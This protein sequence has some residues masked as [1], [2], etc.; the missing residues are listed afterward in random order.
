[1]IQIPLFVLIQNAGFL[2]HENCIQIVFVLNFIIINTFPS[3]SFFHIVEMKTSQMLHSCERIHPVKTKQH[4]FVNRMLVE[5]FAFQSERRFRRI[6]A[7]SNKIMFAVHQ[8]TSSVI[9]GRIHSGTAVAFVNAVVVTS[10]KNFVDIKFQTIR[11]LEPPNR[12]MV[13]YHIC[14]F[15]IFRFLSCVEFIIDIGNSDFKI[16]IFKNVFSPVGNGI[17]EASA[18]MCEGLSAVDYKYIFY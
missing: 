13:N 2:F 14:P 4:T 12:K 11:N 3:R 1:M 10:R 18:R 5:K 7:C 17:V 16:L 8:S 9:D 15:I 6:P